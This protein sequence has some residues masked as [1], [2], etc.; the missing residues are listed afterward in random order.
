TRKRESYEFTKRMA[1]KG[2]RS[3]SDLEA[4]RIAVTQAEI[5]LKVQTV[6]LHVLENFTSKRDI[7]QLEANATEL[8]RELERTKR[9]ADAA[10]T[11]AEDEFESR[12]LTMQVQREKYQEWLS[13]IQNCKL[14]APQSG[15]VVYAN[16]NS[17]SRRGSTEPDIYEGATV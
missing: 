7:A 2:Y 11:K 3:L 1:K 17:Q 14:R 13:Q 8:V 6:N 12:R 10:L 9:K 16:Q 15:E 4:Q 5:E